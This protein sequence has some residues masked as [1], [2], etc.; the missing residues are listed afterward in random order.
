MKI[1]LLLY[2]NVIVPEASHT[3]KFK[4]TLL[5]NG[6]SAQTCDINSNELSSNNELVGR[7]HT[8]PLSLLMPTMYVE[9]VPKTTVRFTSSLEGPVELTKSC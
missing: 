9:E 7:V 2:T 1:F 6:S 3:V 5:P 8:G 4:G